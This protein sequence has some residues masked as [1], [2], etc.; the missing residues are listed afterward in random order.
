MH[1]ICRSGRRIRLKDIT[2][3]APGGAVGCTD[4]RFCNPAAAVGSS[5]RYRIIRGGSRAA[6]PRFT[7][8]DSR[9]N[10]ALSNRNEVVG[11]R[12]AG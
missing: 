3:A 12:L 2:T 11:C 5:L 9:G 6:K 1:Q 4:W 7:L 10:Y 8:A